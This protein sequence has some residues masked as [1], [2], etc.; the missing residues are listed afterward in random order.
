MPLP[1]C[2]RVEVKNLPQEGQQQ[3]RNGPNDEMDLFTRH[4]CSNNQI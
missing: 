4:N 1:Q 3:R 2:A